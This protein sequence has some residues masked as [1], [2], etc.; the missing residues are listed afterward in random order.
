MFAGQEFAQAA[1]DA[2][3]LAL[4]LRAHGLTPEALQAYRVSRAG[5]RHRVANTEWA[6]ISLQRHH[7][8]KCC[9]AFTPYSAIL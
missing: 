3:K 2:H 8:Y 7:Y 1:E 5:R 4:Q 6:S 9:A